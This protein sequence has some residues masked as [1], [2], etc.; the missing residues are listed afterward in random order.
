[1]GLK[2][3]LRDLKEMG[4]SKDERKEIFKN[5]DIG[6]V[7]FE[8]GNYRFISKNDID[9]IMK[10]ELSSDTYMLGCFTAWFIS[11]ITGLDY[12]TVEK[13][14]KNESYELLGELMLKNIDDVVDKYISYDGYG[15]HFSHY[16]GSEA[17]I[18]N[19]YIFRIN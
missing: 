10:D 13:A 3:D 12:N 5:I 9:E 15:H 7:D 16:D 1:M 18:E 14:Q 19:Y 2:N 6:E 17:E 4:F 8:I 11:D